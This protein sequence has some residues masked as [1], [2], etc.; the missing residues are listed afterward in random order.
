M[1]VSKKANM[2]FLV[3]KTSIKMPFLPHG[4]TLCHPMSILTAEIHVK[5]ILTHIILA[6]VLQQPILGASALWIIKI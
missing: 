6:K 1:N 4:G 5:L 3:H 2:V